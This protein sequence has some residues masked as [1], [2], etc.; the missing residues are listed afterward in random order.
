MIEPANGAALPKAPDQ[1][2]RARE[3][4]KFALLLAVILAGF[5]LEAGCAYVCEVAREDLRATRWTET[6]WQGDADGSPVG[7]RGHSRDGCVTFRREAGKE[8]R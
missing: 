7:E 2:K 1:I 8:R 4:K 6:G 5:V 3:T